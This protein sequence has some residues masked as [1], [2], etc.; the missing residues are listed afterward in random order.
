MLWDTAGQEEFDAITKAYYRGAQACVLAFSTTDRDSFEAAH[1]WKLKVCYYIIAYIDHTS[2]FSV[3]FSRNVVT[4]KF[5]QRN[6]G[7]K[8]YSFSQFSLLGI[9]VYVKT[10]FKTDHEKCFQPHIGLKFK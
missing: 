10:V 8:K 1:S 9:S 2:S 5:Q 4:D 6:E 7:N 3:G